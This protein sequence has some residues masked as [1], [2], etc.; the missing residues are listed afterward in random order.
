[1]QAK[2][3]ID[4][5]LGF[6]LSFFSQKKEDEHILGYI[7]KIVALRQAGTN[8]D[9][10]LQGVADF[11]LGGA[12]PDFTDLKARIDAEVDKLGVGYV[13]DPD[14]DPTLPGDYPGGGGDDD[15]GEEEDDGVE[16]E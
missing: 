2:L 8:V 9:Q 3:I 12:E 16:E 1:M 14:P 13:P 6:A 10:H 11:L 5:I 15:D 7:Q 4:L